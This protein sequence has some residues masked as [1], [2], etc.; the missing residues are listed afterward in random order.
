MDLRLRH[1]ASE[2]LARFV[3]GGDDAGG[4]RAVPDD[5]LRQACGSARFMRSRPSRM[6]RSSEWSCPPRS[7]RGRSSRPCHRASP[8]HGRGPSGAGPTHSESAPETRDGLVDGAEPRRW[9]PRNWAASFL[10]HRASFRARRKWPLITSWRLKGGA[11]A[12]PACSTA[13]TSLR[14]RSSGESRG[15]ALR[16]G[17]PCSTACWELTDVSWPVVG[18]EPG[19]GLGRDAEHGAGAFTAA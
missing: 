2:H 16:A 8:A 14:G 19:H 13:S 12:A 10:F 6:W 7:P 11:E 18:D 9:M 4:V 3:V 1:E 5:V 15:L 17:G